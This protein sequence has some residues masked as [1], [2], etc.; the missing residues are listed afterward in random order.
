MAQLTKHKHFQRSFELSEG[1]DR[2]PKPF[3][4]TVPQRW[5]GGGKTTVTELLAWS[6]DQAC[7]IVSR[8]QR[9]VASGG[10]IR[11]LGTQEWC[12]PTNDIQGWISWNPL[13]CGLAASAADVGLAWCACTYV[14]MLQKRQSA[15]AVNILLVVNNWMTLDGN[16]RLLCL[17]Q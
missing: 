11:Q 15:Q 4:Q 5:P 14:C 1:D 16:Y 12:Q 2:L 7:S 13:I 10:N 9:M 6:L 3:R 17:R 8:P